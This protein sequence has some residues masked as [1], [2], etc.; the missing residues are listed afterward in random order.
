MSFSVSEKVTVCFA[1]AGK[2]Y[3]LNWLLKFQPDGSFVFFW[4]GLTINSKM[5]AE[6]FVC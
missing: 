6:T 2:Y 1:V 5:N 3:S 4:C